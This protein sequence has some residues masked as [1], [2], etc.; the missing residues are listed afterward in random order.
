MVS[1]GRCHTAEAALDVLCPVFEDRNISRRANVF[2]LPRSCN[3]TPLDYYLLGTVK[4]K[5]YADKPETIDALK[6]NIREAIGKIQL[7]AVDNVLKHWTDRVDYSISSRG[8]LLNEIIFHHLPEGL[9]FQIRKKRTY[10]E[11]Q[12]AVYTRNKILSFTNL[13]FLHLRRVR[14]KIF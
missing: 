9:Y 8:S 13:N 5:C 1:T 10:R 12:K 6:D 4:D 2:W 7:H 3:L 14:E 11:S